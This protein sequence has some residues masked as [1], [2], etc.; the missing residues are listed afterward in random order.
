VEIKQVLSPRWFVASRVGYMRSN[1]GSTEAYEGTLGLRPSANQLIKAG[2]ELQRDGP[3]NRIDH[4]VGL[5]Y[6]ANIHPLVWS[7]H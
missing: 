4:I 1:L 5:Q 3:G 7:G 2:Y 6:V